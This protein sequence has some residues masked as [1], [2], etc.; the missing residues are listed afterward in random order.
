M[1]QTAAFNEAVET[2]NAIRK[3]AAEG[4]EY[5]LLLLRFAEKNPAAFV[6]ADLSKY[7]TKRDG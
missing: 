3:A 1:N 4:D 6:Q 5:A 2:M 7:R